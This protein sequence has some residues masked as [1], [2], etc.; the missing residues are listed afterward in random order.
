MTSRRDLIKK[1]I[2][3]K[4]PEGALRQLVDGGDEDL[5]Y[6][7]I[8]EAL[9]EGY[10]QMAGLGEV[11]EPDT[12]LDLKTLEREYGFL[13][14]PNFTEEDRRARIKAL[15]YAKP[16]SGTG[17]T[18]EDALALGGFS[19]LVVAEGRQ[20]Q[21]PAAVGAAPAEYIVNGFDYIRSLG[22]EIGCLAAVE[23]SP[24]VFE[25]PVGCKI[26]GGIYV[27][28]C[29]KLSLVLLS[30]NYTA[31]DNWNLVFFVADDITLDGSGFVTS[32]TPATIPRIYRNMIKEIILRIKPL[33]TWCYLAVDWSDPAGFGF[34]F[35]PFGI[36]PHGL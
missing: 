22:Y 36:S 11:R 19:Q 21:D 16:G 23:V 32:M 9:L 28:G 20:T 6:D 10:N 30:P 31:T 13:A 3:V 35:F 1:S 34:G 12:T 5:L 29:S 27:Y 7:G 2:L 15:K 18:L 14:N 33:H 24:G 25:Y 26:S 4:M 8:S 17:E